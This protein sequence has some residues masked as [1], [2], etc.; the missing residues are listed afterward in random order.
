MACN[1]TKGPP[2]IFGFSVRELRQP[3]MLI[4]ELVLSI[5]VYSDARIEPTYV[6]TPFMIKGDH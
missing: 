5:S 1:V 4:K 2:E 3:T 6:S